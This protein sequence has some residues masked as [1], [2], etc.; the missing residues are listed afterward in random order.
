MLVNLPTKRVMKVLQVG[1]ANGMSPNAMYR[2]II[3]TY[4]ESDRYKELQV[5]GF[6]NNNIHEIDHILEYLKDK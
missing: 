2:D 3:K 4:L 1:Q 5:T 6:L